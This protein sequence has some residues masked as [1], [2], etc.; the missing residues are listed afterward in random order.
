MQQISTP[1]LLIKHLYNETNATE[2][3]VVDA[4]LAADATLHD[5]YAQLQETKYALDEA[6]GQAP[7]ASVIEKIMAFSKE[8]ELAASH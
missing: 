2:T 4:A 3:G 6:D 8:Q 5:E 1:E 7:G